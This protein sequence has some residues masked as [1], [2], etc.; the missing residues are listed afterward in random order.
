MVCQD[1]R[2]QFQNIFS[3]AKPAASPYELPQDGHGAME[4]E[5]AAFTLTFSIESLPPFICVDM[6][7]L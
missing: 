6:L 5:A 7:M 3:S 4:S 2:R 1:K